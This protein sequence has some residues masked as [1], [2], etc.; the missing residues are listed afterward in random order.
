MP[1]VYFTSMHTLPKQYWR[2]VQMVELLWMKY[3]ENEF[4]IYHAKELYMVLAK[5]LVVVLFQ[6]S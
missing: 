2:S 4:I 5:K 6:I 1:V 3:V